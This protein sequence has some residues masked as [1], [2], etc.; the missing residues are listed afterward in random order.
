MASRNISGEL[1]V[2]WSAGGKTQ[3]GRTGITIQ[4]SAIHP[5]LYKHIARDKL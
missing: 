3:A 2:R 5:L 4:L 1:C